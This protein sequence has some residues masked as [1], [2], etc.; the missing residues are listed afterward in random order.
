MLNDIFMLWNLSVAYWDSQEKDSSLM[1]PGIWSRRV[2]YYTQ[3]DSG[4]HNNIL[5]GDS[6]GYCEKKISYEHA[7][8]GYRFK[9]IWIYQ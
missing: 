3:D 9:V 8:N 6:I 2:I 5:E 7:S 1:R 4:G